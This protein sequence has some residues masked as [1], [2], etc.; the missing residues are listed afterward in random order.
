MAD[1]PNQNQIDKLKKQFAKNRCTK[2]DDKKPGTPKNGGNKFNFYWIYAIIAVIL[3]G[4]TL[5]DW[6]GGTKQTDKYEFEREML[7]KGHVEKVVL[8]DNKII[9]I[10]ILK[11]SLEKAKFHID[12]KT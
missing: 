7:V 2:G 1:N 12:K 9:K 5:F 6:E 10:F 3:I 4:F 8:V 11:D